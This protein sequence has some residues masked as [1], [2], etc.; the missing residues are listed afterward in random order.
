LVTVHEA[1]ALN[2][3]EALYLV[4]LPA[5]STSHGVTETS[6]GDRAD[7]VKK[8]VTALKGSIDISSFPGKGTSFIIKLLLTLAS[9]RR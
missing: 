5:F 1:Q 3:R 9:S 8:T 2:D 4:F 7:V 6:G